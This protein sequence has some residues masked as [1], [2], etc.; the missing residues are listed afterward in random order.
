MSR[1]VI[2]PGSPQV[3]GQSRPR[4]QRKVKTSPTDITAL[5]LQLNE[6]REKL[7]SAQQEQAV[8]SLRAEMRE[9]EG[10]VQVDR[11]RR[12]VNIVEAC[13]STLPGLGH[14]PNYLQNMIAHDAPELTSNAKSQNVLNLQGTTSSYVSGTVSNE[15]N[16]LV[17]ASGHIITD[18]SSDATAADDLAT[19]SAHHQLDDLELEDF[20]FEEFVS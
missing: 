18:P 5:H 4:P 12:L 11:I 19:L 1:A 17:A 8:Q 15:S 7:Q 10:R 6:L 20:R 16:C 13:V 3:H 2:Q 14:V 9:R